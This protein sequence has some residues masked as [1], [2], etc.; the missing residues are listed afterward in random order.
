MRWCSLAGMTLAAVS[1]LRA[2]DFWVSKPPEQWTPAEIRQMVTDSPWSKR[3]SVRRRS[4]AAG[5]DTEGIVV[6]WDSAT[7]VSKAC[8]QGGMERH[9]F[10]CVSKLLYLSGLADK[11]EQ[12]RSQFYV[13]GLS[14]YPKPPRQAGAPE[15]S[16]AGNAVLEKLSGRIQEST[17]LRRKGR[18]PSKPANVISLPAGQSLLVILFF[19]RTEAIS[20]SDG[21]VSLELAEG[22]IE[23][24]TTFPLQ[25]MF[26]LG[27]LSL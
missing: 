8:A 20:A 14:N 23:L 19:D 6:R 22:G 25:K 7:P 10:S 21:E 27:N 24:E 5:G 17:F 3:A 12:L 11:F 4:G 2:E 13:V 16:D 1:S 18:S 15:H 26:Y 9:L